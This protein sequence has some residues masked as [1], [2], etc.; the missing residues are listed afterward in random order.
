M[1]FLLLVIIIIIIIIHFFIW[2]YSEFIEAVTT[3]II[4][5]DAI[6]PEICAFII[7]RRILVNSRINGVSFVSLSCILQTLWQCTTWA[8]LG[9]T[10]ILGSLTILKASF[11]LTETNLMLV[12]F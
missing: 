10:V 7:Y 6:L 9:P 5:I 8:Q 2:V 1:V 3:S 11:S 12:V 4:P